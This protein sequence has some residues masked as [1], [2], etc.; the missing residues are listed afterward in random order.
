[1]KKT[2]GQNIA[3]LK[4]LPACVDALTISRDGPL[5]RS[6]SNF[7]RP[8]LLWRSLCLSLGGIVAVIKDL[9]YKHA[10]KSSSLC[11]KKAMRK[12][13]NILLPAI[14]FVYGRMQQTNR[15]TNGFFMA[16]RKK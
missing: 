15:I 8:V 12:L 10:R 16:A 7:K 11:F 3:L 5:T 4:E 2:S 9:L 1:V 13:I 14:V 6:V